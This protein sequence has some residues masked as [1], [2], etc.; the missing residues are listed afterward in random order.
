MASPA[1]EPIDVARPAAGHRYRSSKTYSHSI[2]LSCCFRQWRAPSHCRFIHGYAL[3]FRAEFEAVDGLDARNW[4]VDFGALKDFRQWLHDRF[5]HKTLVAVDDPERALFEE[6]HRRGVIQMQLVPATGCEAM[7][8]MVFDHLAQWL[9]DNGYPP[10]QVR[11]RLIEVR[12]HD[13]NGASY[14]RID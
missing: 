9:V 12:E 2:G 14:G 11:L 4:V 5:D 1:G 7:A 10:A 8:R 6:L 3:Q 13:G